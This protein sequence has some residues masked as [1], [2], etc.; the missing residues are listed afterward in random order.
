[1]IYF[2]DDDNAFVHGI[3]TSDNLFDG[4]ITTNLEQYY[5]EP[6][7]KY[8]NDLHKA[9]VHSIVYKISDVE[10]H[11]MSHHSHSLSTSKITAGY[12]RS[13]SGANGGDDN[14]SVVHKPSDDFV[15]RPVESKHC[16]SEILRK[17]FKNEYKKRR[18]SIGTK[19]DEMFVNH[20][21]GVQF[22]ARNK[23]WLPEEVCI[24]NI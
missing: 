3:L 13:S 9:G 16:A 20:D 24:Y 1:M 17:K 19:T 6:S 21:D 12:R 23:R 10:M 15:E 8:S 14:D 18:K 5:I 7:N 2:T 11:Q 4:T 22:K